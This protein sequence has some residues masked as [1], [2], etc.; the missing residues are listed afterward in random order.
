MRF[1]LGNPAGAEQDLRRALEIEPSDREAR[2]LLEIL[3]QGG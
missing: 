2:E 1:Q 3:Q